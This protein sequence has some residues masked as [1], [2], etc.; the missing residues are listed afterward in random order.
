MDL[1]RRWSG[2]FP[3]GFTYRLSDL[4][5]DDRDVG[6]LILNNKV[7]DTLNSLNLLARVPKENFA[8]NLEDA[9]EIIKPMLLQE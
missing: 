4:R 2:A 3:D 9:K 7:A 8:D 5:G 6:R 1:M